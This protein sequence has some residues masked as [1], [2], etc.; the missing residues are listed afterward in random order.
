M[1]AKVRFHRIFPAALLPMRADKSALGTLPAAAHQYCEAVRTASA[2]GWY[3]FPPTDIRLRWDGSETLFA[4][5]ENWRPLTSEHLGSEFL[6]LWDSRAPPELQGRAPPFLSS[7]FIP[8]VVQIWSGLFV[9]SARGWSVLVRPLAN[10]VPSRAFACY[11]GIVETD[12]FGPA[13]LFVNIRLL[14]TEGEISI[15][16]SKPLFQVQPIYRECYSEAALTAGEFTAGQPALADAF[17][18]SKSDWLG[19]RR[20]IRD[21]DPQANDHTIGSYAGEVRRRA[22]Q[23]QL[24]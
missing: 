6:E 19:F 21:I 4:Q 23:L 11:E 3:V 13:P 18:M 12:E 20:T 14:S 10:V 17:G 2:F 5:G 1:G 8:G 24:G 15:S 9:S 22:K 16:R 7:L